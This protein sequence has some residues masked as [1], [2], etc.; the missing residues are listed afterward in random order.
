MHPARRGRAA[1]HPL[2]PLVALSV[3]SLGGQAFAAGEVPAFVPQLSVLLGVSA[4][5]AYLF[6]RLKITP[7]IAFLATGV[8]LGP[9]AAGV[10]TDPRLIDAA[11]EVGVILLLFTIGIEFSLETLNRIRR[12]IFGGGGLQVVGITAFTA[13]VLRA[14]GV[15]WTVGIFTGCLLALS[16]TAIVM[17]LLSDG[18]T[19]STPVGQTALG[20][21]IFQDLAVVG[22]VLLVPMLAGSGGGPGGLALALLTAGAIIAAVLLIARRG[23]PLLLEAVGRTCSQ[24]VFLLTVIGVCFVTA[25]LTSLAGVSLSLGAFL[26]GLMVSESRFGKQALSEIL[27]LQIVFSAAFFLSV[28]LLLDLGFLV[29]NLALVLAVVVGVLVLKGAWTALSARALGLSWA[30]ALPAGLLLAQVGEFGFVLEKAGRDVGL[31]PAGLGEAGTQTFIAATVLLMASTPLLAW[32]GTALGRRLSRD[33]KPTDADAPSEEE[34]FLDLDEH[35]LLLGY[36]TTGRALADVLDEAGIVYGIV[37]LSPSGATQA[38]ERGRH[39]VI[40]DYTRAHILEHANLYGARLVVIPDDDAERAAR[41]TAVI[42]AARPDVP[43]VVGTRFAHVGEE[44]HAA[45]ASVVLAADR[46][47]AERTADAVLGQLGVDAG[48]AQAFIERLDRRLDAAEG[49]TGA[50]EPGLDAPDAAGDRIALSA[51]QLVSGACSHLDLVEIVDAPDEMVCPACVEAGDRWVHLRIC[52][53]CG[54]VGCCDSSPNRHARHHAA[55]QGHPV[56]RSI[57]PGETWAYCYDE[58]VTF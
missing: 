14:F 20:M 32:A 39:V 50:A 45:G 2:A 8:V 49:R 3:L 38:R 1:T 37:T 11:A 21:L 10:V 13:V 6:H 56:I 22:M 43:I 28:G 40:G 29:E 16:S 26:A 35:A 25:Y 42:R 12:L 33:A 30:T 41:A 55:D 34:G 53:T 52:M 57:E 5:I 48:Q 7:I 17:K 23:M 54:H 31:T 47:V 46:A 15:D 4:L 18:G 44:L 58:D 51:E 27:P 19:T 36:G 9:S 24:E